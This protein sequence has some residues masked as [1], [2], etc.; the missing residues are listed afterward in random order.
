MRFQPPMT[1]GPPAYQQYPAQSPYQQPMMSP[2][3]SGMMSPMSGVRDIS[4]LLGELTLYQGMTPLM[5]F[6]EHNRTHRR[7][8]N[9]HWSKGKSKQ[10]EEFFQQASFSLRAKTGLMSL[11][12]WLLS[13]HQE[14]RFLVLLVIYRSTL[15]LTVGG[16][17]TVLY[18]SIELWVHLI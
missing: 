11:V 6:A 18:S 17:E 10:S 15:R 7:L 1:Y 14:A 5:G 13:G 9:P 2:M 3:P 16:G 4:Q 12:A 8:K